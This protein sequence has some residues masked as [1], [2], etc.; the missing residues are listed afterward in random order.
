MVTQPEL[1]QLL[2]GGSSQ[3]AYVH[4]KPQVQF[5]YRDS[6]YC[7]FSVASPNAKEAKAGVPATE[8]SSAGISGVPDLTAAIATI[9]SAA[10]SYSKNKLPPTPPTINTWRPLRVADAPHNPHA[11]FPMILY[12]D[13]KQV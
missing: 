11:Y 4:A 10:K 1:S 12:G 7:S 13:A 8:S 5:G 3:P 9:T 2:L 6:L